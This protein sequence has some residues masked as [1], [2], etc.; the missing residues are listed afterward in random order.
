MIATD[1]SSVLLG[2][3]A[4]QSG[5]LA[6]AARHLRVGSEPATDPYLVAAQAMFAAAS[7]EGDAAGLADSVAMLDGSTYLDRSVAEMAAALQAVSRGNDV[8]AV[9]RLASARALVE[10]T[11][12][13]VAQAIV[14]MVAASVSSRL[15]HPDAAELEVTAQ[16]LL[17][18]L[19]IDPVGWTQILALTNTVVLA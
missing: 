2:M 13:R 18:G 17:A 19:G 8:Q 15:D 14:E 6:A 16:E 3:I 11:E 1:D 7:G 4:L 10:P 9:A 12:D 5:D